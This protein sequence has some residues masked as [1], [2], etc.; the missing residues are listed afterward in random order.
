MSLEDNN[1]FFI[2]S[3]KIDWNQY[4]NNFAWGLKYFIMKE[5]IDPPFVKNQIV[6]TKDIQSK[7]GDLKW[8]S[9]KKIN[10]IPSSRAKIIKRV[11]GNQEVIGLYEKEGFKGYEKAYRLCQS[12]FADYEIYRIKTLAYLIHKLFKRVFDR[13]FLDESKME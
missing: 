5:P 2:D 7:F 12:A 4:M 9:D 6:K 11:L 3:K 8:I 13:V 1:T 10:Y